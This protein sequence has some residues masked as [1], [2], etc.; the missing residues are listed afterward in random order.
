MILP[1]D[2]F[3]LFLSLAAAG[4]YLRPSWSWMS[5]AWVLHGTSLAMTLLGASPHFGFAPALS[6]TAWLMV[7]VYAVERMVYPQLTSRKAVGISV[8]AAVAVAMAVVF[9]GN[10][11]SGH[12]SAGLAIHLAL[13]VASYGLFGIAVVHAWLMRRAEIRFRHAQ[14]TGSGLPLLTLERL[15]YRFI[16]AGFCLLSATLLIGGILHTWRWD[17]KTVFSLLAWVIFSVL[18]IGR[19]G[20]GW[21]GKRAVQVLYTGSLFLLLGYVGS[22]FVLEVI[23]GRMP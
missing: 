13:G 12:F 7:L 18:L 22:R 4:A 9:P 8:T 6:F 21:R 11:L 16:V 23:L 1:S 20:F 5:A 17:H 19:Y 15:T 10:P 3:F 2:P 14:D